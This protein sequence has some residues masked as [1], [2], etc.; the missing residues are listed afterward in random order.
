MWCNVS[1]ALNLLCGC[2]ARLHRTTI[3]FK[4]LILAS[5]LRDEEILLSLPFLWNWA[6]LGLSVPSQ[7]QNWEF[8][9][10]NERKWQKPTSSEVLSHLKWLNSVALKSC[11]SVNLA[12]FIFTCYVCYAAVSVTIVMSKDC[13]EV[14]Q[15][16]RSPCFNPC[17][18]TTH[19]ANLLSSF[20]WGCHNL[21]P[22]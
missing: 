11:S 16:M 9:D 12:Y 18:L 4:M 21:L 8:A 5:T 20:L 15:Q 6:V 22:R 17:V 14:G 10:I 7:T 1:V 19:H 2:L 3:T 13:L